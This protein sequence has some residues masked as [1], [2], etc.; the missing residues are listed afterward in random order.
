MLKHRFQQYDDTGVLNLLTNPYWSTEF[1]N[2]TNASPNIARAST[3]LYVNSRGKAPNYLASPTPDGYL[4]DG[5]KKLKGWTPY[6]FNIGAQLTD[7]V[8]LS[9]TVDNVFD[10]MPPFDGSYPGTELAP[11][12]LFNYNIYGRSYTREMS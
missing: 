4:T 3:T 11:Y 9:A 12:N 2:T 1:R 6:N 8:S 7:H 5:A 10:K